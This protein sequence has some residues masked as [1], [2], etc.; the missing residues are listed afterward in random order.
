M[1]IHWLLSDWARTSP[2]LPD[3]PVKQK[4]GVERKMGVFGVAKGKPV[5]TPGKSWLP[6]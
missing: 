1:F 2:K 5:V 3:L 6:Q 4:A